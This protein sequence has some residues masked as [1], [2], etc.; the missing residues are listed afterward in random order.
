MNCFDLIRILK[1]PYE[2]VKIVILVFHTNSVKMRI[3]I[4]ELNFAGQTTSLPYF[5]FYFRQAI[6]HCRE[7][8][9]EGGGEGGKVVGE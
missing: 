1:F 3:K 8:G 4:L 2:L 9:G 5:S 6:V 7:V